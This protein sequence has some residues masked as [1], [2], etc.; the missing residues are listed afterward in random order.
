MRRQVRPA[1]PRRVTARFSRSTTSSPSSIT[2]SP[3]GA[4]AAKHGAQAREQLVD[5]DRLRD[6]VVGARVER[7][8]LLALLADRRE[9]DHR[10]RAPLPQLAA[11]VD[12]G[13]VGEHEVEDHRLR[14][15]HRR[16]GE[17]ALG[18]VG[19]L[20][21]VARRRAGSCAARAGSAARRRRRARAAA[22]SHA[23]T[24]GAARRAARA[25]TSRPGPSR[26]STQSRPPFA[27]AK[28][29]A[30]ARPSPAPGASP[31]PRAALERLE[32]PL[33]LRRRD[34]RPVVDHAHE[35]LRR[36]RRRPARA[37]ARPA[38]ST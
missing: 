35:R 12:A 18:G 15:A 31:P 8:D 24:G 27:S 33:A 6:V 5:P 19:G 22:A 17:R 38:A 14:R 4:V 37:R 34:A 13:A 30:I 25:R 9:H 21:L 16:G 3:D 7:R 20:D 1:R 23:A 11:D 36:R 10:R 2:G 28:P 26:D 32:D 29:R